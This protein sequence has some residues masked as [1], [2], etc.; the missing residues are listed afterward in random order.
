[1][2]ETR[3][4]SA[5]RRV[6]GPSSSEGSAIRDAIEQFREAMRSAGLEPR[7]VIEPGK[8]HRFS[9]IGKRQSNRAGWCKLFHGG[10]GGCFGDWSSGFSDSWQAKRDKPF[11]SE[12]QAAFKQRVEEAKSQ[13][14]VERK[15]R[16][17]EAAK[18]SQDIWDQAVPAPDDHR[19]LVR[20][21]VR[22]QGLRVY[23]GD[24]RI[25]GMKCDECLI[26]PMRDTACKLRSLQFIAPNGDKRFL[27]NGQIHGCY[28]SIGRPGAVLCVAEGYATGASIHEATGHAVAVAFNAGNA[29][30]VATALRA[31]FRDIRLVLCAD[32]DAATQGNPG[33]TKA[34]EAAQTVGGLLAIPDFGP[35]RPDGAT[36]FNDLHR[37]RS[38]DGARS[39]IL[40]YA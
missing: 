30:A 33:L 4:P 10:L 7:D 1:V 27:P 9:G 34:R 21:Q 8:L 24:L 35:D 14:E 12:E 32:D 36:D 17:A 29:G 6:A 15:Q 40:G 26:V 37:Q 13:A 39:Q 3:E 20:K 11:T 23:R 16:Q 31:K 18:D 38:L 28:F 22:A 19:Y 5:P 25:A 2:E